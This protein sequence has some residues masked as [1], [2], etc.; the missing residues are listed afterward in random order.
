MDPSPESAVAGS[1]SF[2]RCFG[3][4]C[5]SRSPPSNWALSPLG[6][7]SPGDDERASGQQEEDDGAPQR[8]PKEPEDGCSGDQPDDRAKP[9]QAATEPTP[10]LVIIRSVSG[11]SMIRRHDCILSP[12]RQ[13][14]V[15]V[16]PLVLAPNWLRRSSPNSLTADTQRSSSCRPPYDR[17]G[18]SAEPTCRD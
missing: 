14:S 10:I 7:Q 8:E 15:V 4:V 18:G 5:C 12:N 2:P 6:H 3:V 1:P 16:R 11:V 13:L 17:G 9:E